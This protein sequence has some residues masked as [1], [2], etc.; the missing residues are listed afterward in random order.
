MLAVIYALPGY[1]ALGSLMALSA[2]GKELT[3]GGFF[4]VMFFY[5]IWFVKRSDRQNL[6]YM[7]HMEYER[8][9][10][11]AKAMGEETRPL[12]QYIRDREQQEP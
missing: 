8:D 3:L 1:A 4:A 2:G 12:D 10:W 9:Y 7:R 6:R 11:R 5:T